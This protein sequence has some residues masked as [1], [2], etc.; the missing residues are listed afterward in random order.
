MKELLVDIHQKTPALLSYSYF[1]KDLYFVE[2]R[3]ERSACHG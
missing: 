3:D 2:K 1:C